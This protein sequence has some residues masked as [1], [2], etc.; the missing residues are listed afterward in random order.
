MPISI[1]RIRERS[2]NRA[3]RRRAILR[4]GTALAFSTGKLGATCMIEIDVVG[5]AQHEWLENFGYFGQVLG[6]GG[7][8]GEMVGRSALSEPFDPEQPAATRATRQAARTPLMSIE[9]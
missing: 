6:A 5:L 8:S 4:G 1:P 9:T 2:P 3:R 7:R